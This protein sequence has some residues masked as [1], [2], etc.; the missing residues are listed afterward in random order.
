[1]RQITTTV[2]NFSELSDSAKEKV[3]AD[4]HD[5]NVMD[6]FWYESS[7]SMW[8]EDMKKYGVTVDANR[9]T[10]SMFHS[11]GAQWSSEDID[12]DIF[13]KHIDDNYE[14][15]GKYVRLIEDYTDHSCEPQFYT[16][17]ERVQTHFINPTQYN[18]KAYDLLEDFETLMNQFASDMSD[19][20]LKLLGDEYDYFTSEEQIVNTINDIGLEFHEDGTEYRQ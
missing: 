7:L 12:I 4:N 17:S 10:F 15:L 20:L 11:Q 13:T 1:M 5:I 18:G 2:Y 19:E 16:S 9:V 6:E 8:V 14:K 3:L